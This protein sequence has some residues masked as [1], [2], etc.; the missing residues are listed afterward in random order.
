MTGKKRKKIKLGDVYAI[1][2]P[3]GKY[4]FGRVLKDAGIAI[5]SYI[6]ESKED[7]PKTEDYQ[8]IIGVYKDILVSGQWDVVNNRP[9]D[10]EDEAWPPPQCMIDKI[11]GKYSIYYKGEMRDASNFECEGLEIAA[12]WDVHHIID[13][14]MGE[15]KWHR[16]R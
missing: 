4:A 2:L 15:N 6:G 14:I 8:F 11:S 12:V 5:Y 13:R 7:L 3:N 1:P 9:F 10:D 16:R